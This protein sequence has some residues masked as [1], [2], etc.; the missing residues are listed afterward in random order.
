MT[1][2]ELEQAL[3]SIPDALKD[4]PVK[5]FNDVHHEPVCCGYIETDRG[6]RFVKLDDWYRGPIEDEP[7]FSDEQTKNQIE[8]D[9]IGKR[10]FAVTDSFLHLDGTILSLTVFDRINAG[11]HTCTFDIS[12]RC[13]IQTSSPNYTFRNLIF[14]IQRTLKDCH[15]ENC[16]MNDQTKTEIVAIA[17]SRINDWVREEEELQREMKAILDWERANERVEAIRNGRCR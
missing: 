11:I 7:L 4:L 5:Y 16:L 3:K 15:F 10:P 12:Q 2:R 13:Q 6:E 9:R 14:H 17:R 8:T 1:V